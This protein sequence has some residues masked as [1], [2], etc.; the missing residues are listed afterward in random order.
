MNKLTV[1]VVN[2]NTSDLT[3]LCLEHIEQ[4]CQKYDYNII[5]LD[6]STVEKFKLNREIKNFLYIDNTKNEIIDYNEFIK[7]NCS[8]NDPGNYATPKHA[9]AI[10]WMISNS[11]T[12]NLL[13]LDSDAILKK[14][15]DF[16]DEQFCTVAEI[17]KSFNIPRFFP[18]I[19]YINVELFKKYNL[20]FCDPNRIRYGLDPKFILWDTG[21]SLYYDILSKKIKY[22]TIVMNEYIDHMCGASWEQIRSGYKSTI[23]KT[24]NFI[25]KIKNK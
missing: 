11:K 18:M 16:I 14:D 8:G 23:N 15:V 12:K 13:I 7:F 17:N 22:K 2:F 4:Y 6:N 19:Q 3:N 25:E 1:F 21:A 20:K 24:Y 5:L 10:D 9:Y